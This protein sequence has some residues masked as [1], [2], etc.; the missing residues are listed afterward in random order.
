[1]RLLFAEIFARIAERHECQFDG[2]CNCGDEIAKAIRQHA[3]KIADA[4]SVMSIPEVGP[5]EPTV[6]GAIRK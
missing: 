3:K 6:R 1:M 2:K 4:G 5:P